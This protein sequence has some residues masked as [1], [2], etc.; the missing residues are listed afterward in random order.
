[1]PKYLI[2]DTQLCYVTWT[3]EVEADNE[4]EALEDHAE[5]PGE[6]TGIPDIGDSSSA[7]D[8]TLEITEIKEIKPHA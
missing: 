2:K 1:M 8:G 5:Q 3:Y 6:S 4:D 7:Y